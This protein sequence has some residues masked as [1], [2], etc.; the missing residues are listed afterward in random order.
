M[1]PVRV[2]L[3]GAGQWARTMHAPM[4][5]AGRETVLA[6]VWSPSHE[7]ASALAATFGV[8]A[9]GSLD[10]LLSASE[11][12]DFAVPP[13]AQAELALEAAVAGKALLL[14]KPLAASLES[15]ARLV[16]AI[17]SAGVVSMVNLTRRYQARTR[18]FLA[19]AAALPGGALAITGRYVHGG[20]LETGFVDEAERNGWRSD[21]GAL[22]DLGPHLLDLADAAAGRIRRVTSSGDAA[23]V[24]LL[25]TEHEGGALGQFVI[26]GRVETS[27]VLAGIDVY[28]EAGHLA[29]S[30][31]GLEVAEAVSTLRSEFAAAVRSGAPAAIDA[32]RALEVQRIVDAAA[33]S[34]AER[35]PVDVD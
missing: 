7:R 12:V 15:A 23:E 5:A 33:R 31:R 26:S 6:G 10:E 16:D 25:S 21:L 35:R 2:G 27:E 24:V 30:T 17:D 1:E 28:G 18:E 11:A 9:F 19:R 32:H 20:F 34:L 4:H 13:A 29:Y 22:F 14:E 3:V 8:P